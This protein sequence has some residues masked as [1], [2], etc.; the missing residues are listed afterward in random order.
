MYF[1][2]FIIRI[3]LCVWFINLSITLMFEVLPLHRMEGCWI[4]NI[5]NVLSPC[6][7]Q[8]AAVCVELKVFKCKNVSI[9]CGS[10]VMSVLSAC[11]EQWNCNGDSSCTGGS[12]F[13]TH[14]THRFRVF[15]VVSSGCF[16]SSLKCT[17]GGSW[18]FSFNN[19]S[20]QCFKN[21]QLIEA[22]LKMLQF[23]SSFHSVL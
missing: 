9:R 3:V 16:Y 6:D 21:M 20:I 5:L 8:G 2:S 7:E 12:R 4:Y 15:V 22:T 10:H 23:R 17:N 14:P 13:V 1:V 19:L 11:E 18:C